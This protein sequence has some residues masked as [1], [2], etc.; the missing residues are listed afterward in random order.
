MLRKLANSNRLRFLFGA[1]SIC[2]IGFAVSAQDVALKPDE[3]AEY[4]GAWQLKGD[5]QGNPLNVD[6]DL[7][8]GRGKVLGVLSMPMQRDA[9]PVEQIRK[10]DDGLQLTYEVSFGPQTMTMDMLLKANGDEMTGSLADSNGFFNLDLVG[11]RRDSE[12]P[13]SMASNLSVEGFE[14][15]L[16]TWHLMVD[17]GGNKIPLT[18][19]L[20][21]ADGK[22]VGILD[23]MMAPEPQL[24]REMSKSG[25]GLY[26]GFKSRMGAQEMDVAIEIAAAESGVAGSFEEANGLFSAEFTGAKTEQPENLLGRTRFAVAKQA[27]ERP[28]EGRRGRGGR[29]GASGPREV[30]TSIEGKTVRIRYSG[31]A[32]DSADYAA[33]QN[34]KDGEVVRFTSARVIKMLNE[35]DLVFGD[36]TVN[37]NNLAPDYPGVYGLWIRRVGNGWELV[38]NEQGDVWGTQHDPAKDA[39]VVPLNHAEL[40]EPAANL[41]LSIDES[42]LRIAWGAHEWTAAFSGGN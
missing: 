30:R 27:A 17:L 16:G 39:H 8:D 22:M 2:C 1:M 35:V 38:F 31:E 20:G 9:A 29:G 10:T 34:L 40:A 21:D 24:I 6:L 37:A 26:M 32:A 23:S 15:L 4:L 3:A 41:S 12:M 25:E 36:V 5:F 18:L 33:I 7:F 19:F 11:G 28:E 42:T 14:N 13:A